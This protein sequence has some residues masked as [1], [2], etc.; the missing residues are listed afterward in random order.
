MNDFAKHPPKDQLI[1]FG[2]GTLGSNAAER[3]AEHLDDCSQCSETMINLQDDTFVALVRN[4]P[5]PDPVQ[6]VDLRPTNETEAP[7]QPTIGRASESADN[8]C[9]PSDL[10]PD[11]ANIL[12]TT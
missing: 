4:S 3:V 8:T 7:G 12:V 9:Q 5:A 6:D 1:A 2:L 10:P 11:F